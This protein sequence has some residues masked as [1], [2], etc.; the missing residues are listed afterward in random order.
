ME[1]LH[2]WAL[3]KAKELPATKRILIT[4]HDAYNYFGR[5]YGFQVVGLQGISTVSEVSLADLAKMVDCAGL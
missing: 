5:A 2:E 3:A 4:S 1:A